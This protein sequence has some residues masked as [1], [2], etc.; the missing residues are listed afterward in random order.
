[1]LAQRDAL[2]AVLDH[3]EAERSTVAKAGGHENEVG[4]RRMRDEDL[5]A[6]EAPA[7]TGWQRGERDVGRIEAGISLGD[8]WHDP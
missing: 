1:M 7:V 6:R 5:S 4:R 8:G 3:D 2:A